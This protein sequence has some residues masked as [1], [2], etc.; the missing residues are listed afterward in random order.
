MVCGFAKVTRVALV[1]EFGVVLFFNWTWLSY[2]LFVSH[3]V[4]KIVSEKRYAIKLYKVHKLIHKFS[5]LTWFTGLKS[6]I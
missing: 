2:R 6:L 5:W 3:V 4:K 1:Y